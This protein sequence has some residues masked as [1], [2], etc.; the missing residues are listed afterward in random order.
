MTDSELMERWLAVFGERADKGQIKKHVTSFG[1][2]L[3]HLFSWEL[4]PSIEGDDAKMAFDKLYYTEAIK[5]H[6]G[7]S[8]H[9]QDVVSMGKVSAQEIETESKNGGCIDVYVVAKDFS[10]TYVCTHEGDWCGPYLCVK[11]EGGTM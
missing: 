10:W 9:I 3:W 7:Y 8:G 4:V 5:F 6:D 2:H 11:A 1:N